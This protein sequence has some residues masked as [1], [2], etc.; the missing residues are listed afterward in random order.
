MK[1]Y[2]YFTQ[3]AKISLTACMIIVVCAATYLLLSQRRNTVFGNHEGLASQHPQQARN[4]I[5]TAIR[6]FEDVRT[7]ETTVILKGRF[8]ESEY[9]GAGK[10]REKRTPRSVYQG[11]NV[12][13]FLTELQFQPIAISNPGAKSSTLQIVCDG[14][15]LWK[16]MNI[17]DSK[18]LQR[19]RVDQIMEMIATSKKENL[20]SDVSALPFLGTI[21]GTLRELE[22]TYDL[23]G[24]TVEASH[25][26]TSG[27]ELWRISATLR[28]EARK[29]MIPVHSGKEDSDTNIPVGI[30]VYLDMKTHFPVQINYYGETQG[31]IDWAVPMLEQKYRNI[32]ININDI[33]NSL[34]K[35]VPSA[36]VMIDDVTDPYARKIGLQQTEEEEE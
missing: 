5:D 1:K 18:R 31:E 36:D 25:A 27:E 9:T 14:S 34:F 8:Y 11:G 6:A 26:E 35:Y 32:E 10:Y 3:I 33:P 16:Y 2:S 12:C 28:S 21:E 19:I 23:A 4:L 15:T 17:E 20:W 13:T 22:N 24:A 30:V 7:L 29:K